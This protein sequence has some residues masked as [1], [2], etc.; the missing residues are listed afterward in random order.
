MF[1]LTEPFDETKF[2][3]Y[4]LKTYSRLKELDRAKQQ[5]VKFSKA[6]SEF[7]VL[8]YHNVFGA[9]GSSMD[10]RPNQNQSSASGKK[11]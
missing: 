1:D 3:R 6:F 2:C 7:T 5:G 11:A 8:V 10:I 9:S 4:Y